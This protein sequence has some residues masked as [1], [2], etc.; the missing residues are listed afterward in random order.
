MV[1]SSTDFC[2]DIEDRY[3]IWSPSKE[4]N[5]TINC[6]VEAVDVKI[7]FNRGRFIYPVPNCPTPAVIE[8]SINI[9]SANNDKIKNLFEK[10]LLREEK[11]FRFP[12]YKDHKFEIRF[13]ENKSLI[14]EKLS[15]EEKAYAPYESPRWGLLHECTL[16]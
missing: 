8:N 7:I 9:T 14:E 5:E 13:F 11:C 3:I 2:S 4:K 16:L 1:I 10:Y 15:K 12:N 6:Q